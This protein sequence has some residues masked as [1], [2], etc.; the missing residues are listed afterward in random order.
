MTMG[1]IVNIALLCVLLP[2]EKTVEYFAKRGYCLIML[3]LLWFGLITVTNDQLALKEGKTATVALAENIVHTL[4]EEG[5]LEENLPIA[6]VGRPAENPLFYR[7]STVDGANDYARFGCWSI[8]AGNHTRTWYGVLY[9]YCG[10]A[11]NICGDMQYEAIRQNELVGQM[12]EFPL[13]GSI[14]E[15]DGVVVVKVSEVY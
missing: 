3:M 14:R 6:L 11:L 10:T 2:Q 12:P 5:Y 8:S 4:S 15:I 7:S 13:E 1:V 9:N